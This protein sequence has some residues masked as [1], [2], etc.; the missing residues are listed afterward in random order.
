MCL[1]LQRLQHLWVWGPPMLVYPCS[2]SF[3]CCHRGSTCRMYC[4]LARFWCTN[5]SPAKE[6]TAFV[7]MGSTDAC[8]PT[9]PYCFCPAT[10]RVHVSCVLAACWFD[11]D[12]PIHRQTAIHIHSTTSQII[13]PAKTVSNRTW[14]WTDRGAPVAYRNLVFIRDKPVLWARGPPLSTLPQSVHGTLSYYEVVTNCYAWYDP[15]VQYIS[16]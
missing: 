7:S 14:G 3:L 1:L 16:G 8:V 15:G 9:I 11:S 6:V 4:L 13:C 10:G 5:V 12:T 2:D